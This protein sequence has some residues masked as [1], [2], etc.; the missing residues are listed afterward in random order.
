MKA[1][2]TIHTQIDT[3]IMNARS[4]GPAVF[5]MLKYVPTTPPRSPK[6]PPKSPPMSPGSMDV[7]PSIERLRLRSD[8]ICVPT[9][10][11]EARWR[12][13]SA[14]PRPQPG[15]GVVVLHAVGRVPFEHQTEV[16][17]SGG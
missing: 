10:V 2:P 14:D 7:L 3:R 17:S 8:L 4:R 1:A 11:Q 5:L 9:T 15:G 12:A 13:R 16:A 6:P